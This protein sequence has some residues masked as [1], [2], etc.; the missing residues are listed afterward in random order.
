MKEL[1]AA[2]EQVKQREGENYPNWVLDQLGI[3]SELANRVAMGR[4]LKPPRFRW[5]P[6]D[7]TLLFPLNNSSLAA[8]SPD[9]KIFYGR[10]ELLFA[11]YLNQLNLTGVP[12]TLAEY[13]AKIGHAVAG[14]AENR[15]GRGDKVRSRLPAGA[16]FRSR[17]RV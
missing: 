12:P 5:V 6:F 7:D 2:K 9:R 14:A 13:T 4:G 15:R 16:G 10:E 8:Q 11:R 3:E 1:V 17:E